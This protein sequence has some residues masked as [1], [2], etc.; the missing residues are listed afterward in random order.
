MSSC[1]PSRIL[2]RTEGAF[3]LAE[4]FVVMAISSVL[5]TLAV[6]SLGSGQATSLDSGGNMVADIINQA[7][8]NAVANNAMTA[9]ILANDPTQS[10]YNRALAVYQLVQPA[11][12]QTAA[13]SDWKQVG[14]WQTLPAGII[15]DQT[16]MQPS[17][18]ST[19]PA[20][21]TISYHGV[22]VNGYQ[23]SIFLPQG[24]LMGGASSQLRLASGFFPGGMSS[25]TYTGKKNSDGT[26]TDYYTISVIAAT[27]RVKIDRP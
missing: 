4:M 20:F 7:S 10:S 12:G 13:S 25:P 17:S 27:G 15:V 11:N 24:N 19:V 9:V 8:Q 6:S 16:T 3:S 26:P 2:R 23:Y 21:P 22:A 14:K 1:R 18:Q 5:L